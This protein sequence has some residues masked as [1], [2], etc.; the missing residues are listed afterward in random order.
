MSNAAGKAAKFT[1]KAL[2]LKVIGPYLAVFF[3]ILAVL[4]FVLFLVISGA[5]TGGGRQE[6]EAQTSTQCVVTASDTTDKKSKTVNV[7]KEYQEPI[8][9]AA[10]V[11]GLPEQV[12]AAQI[13]QESG[14][15]AQAGSPAGA[16]GP[17]QFMPDT[18]ARYG[19]GGDIHSVKDSLD[20]YGRYMK[21][22]REQVKKYANGDANKEVQL[23]LAAYN[24]GPGAVEKYQGIPPYPETE[25][26]VS[27][28]TGS[29]QTKFS[30]DCAA[31]DGGKAWD[32]DLGKGE[33]TVP[34]PGGQF[35]S[36][37][38]GRN[39]PGLPDWAQNHVGVD[40]ST[41]GNAPIIAPTD[42]TVT[43]TLP[44]DH[45]VMAKMDAKPGFQFAFCH[46]E[47]LDVKKGQ[48]IKRGKQIGV[49]SGFMGGNPSGAAKHL[50]FEI[51]KPDC[52]GGKNGGMN[53]PYDGCNLDPEPILKQKGAWVK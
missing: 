16:Q 10:K 26:Y 25:N 19:N 21:D 47:S 20:A 23:T 39:V 40:L 8:K 29:G 42:M 24:A 41:G 38:G 27:I 37:Y 14:F 30:Q 35:T 50:H 6:E 15:N 49:E 7:P 18:W 22:L 48:K 52:A 12:A 33:W 43:G 46:M 4:L 17:A 28:I 36:G 3:A 9:N 34:L 11:S 32:G 44:N 13:K 53:I 1:A 31:S 5:V 45:C 51:Y 2:I